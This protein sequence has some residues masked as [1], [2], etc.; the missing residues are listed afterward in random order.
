MAWYQDEGAEE[1]ENVAAPIVR[2]KD[3]GGPTADELAEHML[4][5]LPHRAWCPICIKAR[6]KE[7]PHFKANKNKA[8]G[9]RPTVSF[10]YK[11][12]GQENDLD[13]K[14]NC[15]IIRDTTKTIFTYL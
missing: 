6:G 5:H 9:Q 1:D 15:L 10:D 14:L 2:V 8:T 3:P 4:T 11:S 12:Y 7:D 13:D